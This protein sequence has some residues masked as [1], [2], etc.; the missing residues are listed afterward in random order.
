MEKSGREARRGKESEMDQRNNEFK[1][2][3]APQK[4]WF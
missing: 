1:K 3:K 2:S 4:T